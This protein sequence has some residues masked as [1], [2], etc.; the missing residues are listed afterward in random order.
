M[1]DLTR[2][3]AKAVKKRLIDESAVHLGYEAICG[4]VGRWKSIYY[5]PALE[6]VHIISAKNGRDFG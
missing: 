3:A 5:V 1:V 4:G 6:Y 2:P